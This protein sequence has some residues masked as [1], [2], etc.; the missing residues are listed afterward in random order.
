MSQ[1]VKS[2]ATSNNHTELLDLQWL[3]LCQVPLRA[4]V[5]RSVNSAYSAWAWG[6]PPSSCG[7]KNMETDVSEELLSAAVD[8]LSAV[9]L[10]SLNVATY[11]KL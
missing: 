7:A 2:N 8:V 11:S 3:Y 4:E 6:P 9:S 1:T 5:S 10:F